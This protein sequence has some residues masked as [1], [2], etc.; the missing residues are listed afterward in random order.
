MQRY[1]YNNSN[2]NNNNNN[3]NNYNNNNN[4]N[5][6]NNVPFII[7]PLPKI[8]NE[9]LGFYFRNCGMQFLQKVKSKQWTILKAVT[10]TYVGCRLKCLPLRKLSLNH[11]PWPP[12]Q[13]WHNVKSEQCG[14]C[15]LL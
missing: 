10:V 8:L 14:V 12:F 1:I 2:N 3:N 11:L 13:L 4:N 6:K 9:L 15:F 5:N 7:L